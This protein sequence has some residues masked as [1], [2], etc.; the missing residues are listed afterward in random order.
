MSYQLS[1]VLE[2]R[3]RTNPP[4]YYRPPSRW[5]NFKIGPTLFARPAHTIGAFKADKRDDLII[6]AF[7]AEKTITN[8]SPHHKINPGA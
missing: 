2:S 6:G 3:R 8:F 7:K 1:R 5:D 4:N